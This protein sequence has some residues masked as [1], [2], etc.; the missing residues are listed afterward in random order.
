MRPCSRHPEAL[1]R[2][3]ASALRMPPVEEW[4]EFP[5]DGEMRRA[6]PSPGRAGGAP[7]R[8]GRRRL[9]GAA[10]RPTTSSSGRTSAG[11]CSPARPNGLP[12][13]VLLH[14]AITTPSPV[15]SPRTWPRSSACCSS[16][17]AGDPRDR[18]DRPRP[19]LPL[20]RRRR[21][22]PLVVHG[23]AGTDPA[24]DRELRGDLGRHPAAA[25][26]RKSGARTSPPWWPR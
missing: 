1:R 12:L 13:V 24:T 16:G 25:C 8:R 17:R 7:R 6:P 26:P 5:F 19:R 21:T 22:P 10:P 23:A 14:L 4:E 3:S 11:A 2:A 9:L 20:G 18:R 15:T